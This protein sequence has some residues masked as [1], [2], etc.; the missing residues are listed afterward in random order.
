MRT[1]PPSEASRTVGTGRVGCGL[2]ASAVGSVSCKADDAILM[3]LWR[4][5][6]CLLMKKSRVA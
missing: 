1:Q 6:I 3:I 5:N 2:G 4:N